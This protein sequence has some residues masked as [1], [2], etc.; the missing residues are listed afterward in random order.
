M[1]VCWL[2]G[3]LGTGFN[4]LL[5]E[6][7]PEAQCSSVSVMVKADSCRMHVSCFF[8]RDFVAIGALH[9]FKGDRDAIEKI[10]LAVATVSETPLRCHPGPSAYSRH[11]DRH[12]QTLLDRKDRPTI[13]L[14]QFR[15]IIDSDRPV[16]LY[17]QAVQDCTVILIPPR[18]S[19]LLPRAR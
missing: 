12:R 16:S 6:V 2:A 4:T 13:P 18:A 17:S 7:C 10:S 15:S 11:C 3:W 19:Q 1:F 14:G 8:D 9:S 5:Y